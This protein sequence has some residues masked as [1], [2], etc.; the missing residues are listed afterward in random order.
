MKRRGLFCVALLVGGLFPTGFAAPSACAS[1]GDHAV[2]VID[3]G[4]S[5]FALCVQL[6]APVVSGLELIELAGD[7]YDLQYRFGYGG[8]AVCQLAN[9]PTTPPP[10]ECFE[11]GKPFWGYWRDGDSGDWTWSGTGAATTEVRDG[12]VEGWSFG[13]GNSGETHPPPPLE[14]FDAACA[15]HLATEKQDE[16]P[17]DGQPGPDEERPEPDP[18]GGAEEGGRGRE[19]G[20]RSAEPAHGPELSDERRLDSAPE[21]SEFDDPLA[22]PVEPGDEPSPQPSLPAGATSADAE[23]QEFPA[24]G[25]LAIV[26][27]IAMAG[28]AAYLLTKRKST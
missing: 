11:Q 22:R 18:T 23:P 24:A 4:S 25:I 8:R 28:V 21:P 14:D 17:P 1:E 9:V 12:D 13:E 6:N 2:L 3:D 7:Q 10:D 15:D 26:A 27:T 20:D 19:Q 16:D 5:D